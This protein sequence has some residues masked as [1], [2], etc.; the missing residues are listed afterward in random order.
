MTIS[1]TLP[2]GVL[3]VNLG[4]GSSALPGWVN[5]DNSPNARLS[6][7][8]G[9][10]TALWR[11]GFLSDVHYKVKWPAN[12]RIHDLTNPL[13]FAD[14]SVGF[15]YSS[16]ALEHLDREH[17]QA[18]LREVWR[19]LS[20]AGIFRLVVPDLE[21]GIR[22]Y[23]SELSGPEAA[24]AATRLLSW[25]QLGTP[26]RRAPHLWMYDWP[27]LRCSLE[28]VGFTDIIRC[29]YRQGAMPDCDRL[30]NRPSDSLHVEARR[31][32]CH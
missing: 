6:R 22:R 4:C 18:L 2:D 32:E 13:P 30:D 14:Q 21:W 23:T 20:P 28:K 31:P 7:F 26:G 10:R 17:A 8:P 15:V 16:H 3:G 5:I 24:D 27:S 11:L 9:V 25:L 29:G 12:I 19:V 1:R